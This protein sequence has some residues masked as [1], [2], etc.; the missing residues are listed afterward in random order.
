[1]PDRAVDGGPFGLVI[2]SEAKQS[3]DLSRGGLLGRF[4]PR[5]DDFGGE[6]I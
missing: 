4:A 1:L 5:T 2:A 3:S 6:A